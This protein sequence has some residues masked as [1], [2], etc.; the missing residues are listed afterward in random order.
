MTTPHWIRDWAII[1]Y[2]VWYNERMPEP[3]TPVTIQAIANAF[4]LTKG[5]VSQIITDCREDRKQTD[6][7]FI[8]MIARL[9]DHMIEAPIK[10]GKAISIE[11]L[12]NLTR[13]MEEA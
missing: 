6:E 5:R 1:S 7:F 2:Y 10:D 13:R 3:R 11:E 12:A 9:L 8:I 4:G